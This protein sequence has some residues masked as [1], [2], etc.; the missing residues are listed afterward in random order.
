M[1]TRTTLALLLPLCPSA[2]DQSIDGPVHPVWEQTWVP[3]GQADD[4]ANDVVTSATQAWVA[5]GSEGAQTGEGQAVLRRLTVGAGAISWT[6][7]FGEANRDEEFHSVALSADGTTVFAAGSSADPDGVSEVYVVHADATT[8]DLLWS[9]RWDSPYGSEDAAFDVAVSPDGF[10]VFLTGESRVDISNSALF[11]LALDTTTG[12]ILWFDEDDPGLGLAELSIAR[13]RQILVSDDSLTTYVVANWF[14][15]AGFL[16]DSALQV[17]AHKSG[18]G[19]LEWLRNL[20]LKTAFSFVDLDLG[21]AL[22]GAQNRLYVGGDAGPSGD[23]LYALDGA[24][25][26]TLWSVNNAMAARELE[27]SPDGAELY[28]ILRTGSLVEAARLDPADGSV[29]W[30]Q[31]F[32]A[33]PGYLGSSSV[34]AIAFDAAQDR[35]HA[36]TTTIDGPELQAVDFVVSWDKDSGQLSAATPLGSADGTDFGAMSL[37]PVG[38][39]LVTCGARAVGAHTDLDAR[40]VDLSANALLWQQSWGAPAGSEFQLGR[41]VFASDG[42]LYAV[43]QTGASPSEQRGLLYGQAAG[44]GPELFSFQDPGTV[45]SR[46]FASILSPDET[47]LYAGGERDDDLWLEARDA[48]SGALLWELS[49]DGPAGLADAVTRLDITSDGARLVVGGYSVDAGGYEDALVQVVQAS[50]GQVIWSAVE[51]ESG[52]PDQLG[53]LLA[54][55]ARVWSVHRRAFASGA[56]ANV[57]TRARDLSTGALLWAD[58]YG[59]IDPNEPGPGGFGVDLELAPNGATLY[60]L[61]NNGL[62]PFQPI[63]SSLSVRALDAQTGAAQYTSTTDLPGALVLSSDLAVAPDGA[64]LYLAAVGAN[65]GGNA[66]LVF[67]LDAADGALQWARLL[68]PYGSVTGIVQLSVDPSGKDLILGSVAEEAP[69]PDL[70]AEFHLVSFEASSGETQW[71][72]YDS[73]SDPVQTAH[74]FELAADG[75]TV[76]AAGVVKPS[77]S[78]SS[79][80]SFEVRRDALRADVT[81]VS[82]ASGGAQ[83]FELQPGVQFA[84]QAHLILGTTS[85]TDAG[86]SLGGGLVLPLTVDNYTTLFLTDAAAS[87]VAGA[88]G[89]LD[90]FG[91]SSAALVVPAQTDPGL[92]GLTLHHAFVVLQAA[93]PVAVSNPVAVELLP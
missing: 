92:A 22:D 75:V 93:V 32:D 50:D 55:D 85:G 68:G 79:I 72:V 66:E 39:V 26:A 30:Q 82:L 34:E 76:R 41:S 44:G 25:G 61:N 7:Q 40:G 90:G 67:A 80:R 52:A 63:N 89:G 33:N 46:Y 28:A 62:L 45:R 3:P 12:Q 57:E 88:L 31:L 60:V 59:Q 13:G 8:G 56:D 36:Y 4:W 47:R 10:R 18:T 15:P 2:Q 71:E 83:S 21:A 27:L 87:P 5:G 84:G 86:L 43:G 74:A 24:D 38:S 42:R 64:R 16:N 17:R 29:V 9:L 70:G 51:G 78:S 48:F 1:L 19:T 53:A 73:T 23:E 81:S 49:W 91:Q 6:N 69:N 65:A 14:T 54:D 11:V 77:A 35:L 58:S 20:P 37:A